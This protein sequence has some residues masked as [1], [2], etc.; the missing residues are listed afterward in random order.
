MAEGV[1]PSIENVRLMVEEFQSINLGFFQANKE[2][3]IKAKYPN[4]NLIYETLLHE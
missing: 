3:S 1:D 2:K 4:M